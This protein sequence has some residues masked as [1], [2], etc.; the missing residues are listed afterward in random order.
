MPTNFFVDGPNLYYAALKDKMIRWLDLVTW[1]ERMFPQE[2]VKRVRVLH[3]V[4]APRPKPPAGRIVF[5]STP[6]H[7][8]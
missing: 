2:D 4:A 7:C 6:A 1:C 5:W 3:R 8:G